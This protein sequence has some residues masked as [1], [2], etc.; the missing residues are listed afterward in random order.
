MAGF[1]RLAANPVEALT[2]IP[3]IAI[4]PSTAH[5]LAEAGVEPAAVAAA[6]SPAGIVDAL[7]RVA[8]AR[9]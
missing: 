9:A 2:E 8:H 3:A 5:A 7:E 4:G 6:P 1:F